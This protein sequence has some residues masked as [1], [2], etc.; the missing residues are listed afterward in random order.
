ML[1]SD[2]LSELSKLD[3]KAMA[4]KQTCTLSKFEP[5]NDFTDKNV[6]VSQ[7]L[8]IFIMTRICFQPKISAT[9]TNKTQIDKVPF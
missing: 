8:I 3:I 2:Y 5:F 6:N 1:E 4:F 9:S 7:N